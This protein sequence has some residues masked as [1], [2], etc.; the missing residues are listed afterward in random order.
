MLHHS[1]V[2][3][4]MILLRLTQCDLDDNHDAPVGIFKTVRNLVVEGC[5]E[6]LNR[7]HGPAESDVS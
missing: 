5:L 3:P 2:S 6:L 1:T 4:V 7:L